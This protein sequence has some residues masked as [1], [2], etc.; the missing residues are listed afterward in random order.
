MRCP[1]GVQS[2]LRSD[3]RVGRQPAQRRAGE[4]VRPHIRRGGEREPRA[5]GRHADVAVRVQRK[6]GQR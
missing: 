4:I 3:G 1:S 2:G 6:A 5:V